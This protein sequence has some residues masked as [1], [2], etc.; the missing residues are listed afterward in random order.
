MTDK[1]TEGSYTWS[2]GKPADF[3][4]WGTGEPNALTDE[5][6]CVEMIAAAKYGLTYDGTWNDEVCDKLFNYVCEIPKADVGKDIS[7]YFL[8]LVSRIVFP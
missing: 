6:D 1:E 8:K 4:N 3:T 2:N 7:I 5:M